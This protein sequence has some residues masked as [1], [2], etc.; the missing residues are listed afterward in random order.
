MSS[1][2][3]KLI[4][5]LKGRAEMSGRNWSIGGTNNGDFNTE[6]RNWDLIRKKTYEIAISDVEE[7]MKADDMLTISSNIRCPS[8]IGDVGYN[9]VASEDMVIRNGEISFVKT[10][11]KVKLPDGYWGLITARSS[12]VF[13]LAVLVLP[14]VIDT[15][16]VGEL[17]VACTAINKQHI[18]KKGESI[19]QLILFPSV[20]PELQ[21]VEVLPSTERGETGF[22]STGILVDLP[23]GPGNVEG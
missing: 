20:T 1:I 13:K 22:G 19:A 12:A 15:G 4:D 11:V 18:L 9:L 16:Y 21:L 7:I 6:Q 8:K 2:R 3:Q 14:G 5:R 23:S 17:M 10:G